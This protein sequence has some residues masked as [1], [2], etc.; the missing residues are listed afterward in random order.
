MTPENAAQRAVRAPA[1]T[2]ENREG[3]QPAC[4]T[5]TSQGG[6]MSKH[7]RPSTARRIAHRLMALLPAV[8]TAGAV[9]ASTGTAGAATHHQ[10]TGRNDARM[11]AAFNHWAGNDQR[12]DAEVWARYLPGTSDWLYADGLSFA[13]AIHHHAPRRVLGDLFGY[14]WGDCNPDA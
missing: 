13:W 3:T 5:T 2:P 12:G 9:L 7:R 6:H 1:S 10:H 4:L 11:C 8:V 14:V